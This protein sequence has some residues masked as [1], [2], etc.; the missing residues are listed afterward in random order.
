LFP[1]YDEINDAMLEKAL[2][3]H[4]SGQFRPT[5]RFAKGLWGCL[6]CRKN[7]LP[8]VSKAIFDAQI[9]GLLHELR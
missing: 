6:Q 8:N 9:F 5:P 7:R 1:V 3:Y 2:I 4:S